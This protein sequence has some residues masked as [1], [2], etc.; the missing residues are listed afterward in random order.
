MVYLCKASCITLTPAGGSGLV[1]ARTIRLTSL[2]SLSGEI[3]C[4]RFGRGR[5]Q[6]AW[7]RLDDDEPYARTMNGRD[8]MLVRVTYCRTRCAAL[9]AFRHMA[10][11]IDVSSCSC[12]GMNCQS[13]YCADTMTNHLGSCTDSTQEE[14]GQ[15]SLYSIRG[16]T[17]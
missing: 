1:A 6:G 15:V 13:L 17:T 3:K 7:T 2:L 14:E 5:L 11:F 8:S 10:E 12:S 16:S 4:C 9:S